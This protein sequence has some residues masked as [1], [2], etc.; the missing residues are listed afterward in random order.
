VRA[1]I[2]ADGATRT[3]GGELGL[4]GQ[5]ECWRGCYLF[6]LELHFFPDMVG[7]HGQAHGLVEHDEAEQDDDEKVYPAGEQL[8][9][10]GPVLS[11]QPDDRR[12]DQPWPDP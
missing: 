11:H 4:A 2:S 1:S 5:V 10:A 3:A 7:V 6:F 12:P 8:Q 9:G